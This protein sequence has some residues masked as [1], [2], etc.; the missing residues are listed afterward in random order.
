G[1]T[2]LMVAACDGFP[3]A[4]KWLLHEAGSDANVLLHTKPPYGNTCKVIEI[5]LSFNADINAK[6]NNGDTPLMVGCVNGSMR[7]EDSFLLVRSGA[8]I[9]TKNLLGETALHLA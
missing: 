6:D 7:D 9:E 1:W 5:L 3:E 8:N 2:L 4:V